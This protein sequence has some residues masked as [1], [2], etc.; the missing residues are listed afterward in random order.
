[1]TDFNVLTINTKAFPATAPLVCKKGER[2]RIRLGNLSAMD[3]HPIHLHGYLLQ[4]HRDRRRGRLPQSA[5]WPETAVL[6]PVGTTR[7]IEL[8]ADA[9]ETGRCIA[10]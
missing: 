5:Q 9:R 4:G 7:T 3:H 2:V 8:V 1:M 10:T 6:V